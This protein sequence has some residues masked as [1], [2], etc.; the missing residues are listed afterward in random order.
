M[1]L[2]FITSAVGPWKNSYVMSIREYFLI[3][4]YLSA[5]I[6]TLQTSGE[7]GAKQWLCNIK[8]NDGLNL[9]ILTDESRLISCDNDPAQNVLEIAQ[10]IR[11]GKFK[12]SILKTHGYMVISNHSSNPNKKY[13]L[14]TNTGI[15]SWYQDYKNPVVLAV[16]V[17]SGL[18]VLILVLILRFFTVP[19][20]R[21]RKKIRTISTGNLNADQQ[22]E[23]YKSGGIKAFQDLNED[24]NAMQAS[25]SKLIG[26]KDEVIELISHEIKSPLARQRAALSLIKKDS[27][28]QDSEYMERIKLENQKISEVIMGSLEYIKLHQENAITR[29][30]IFDITKTIADVIDDVQ[31]QYPNHSFNFFP[32]QSTQI[33]GDEFLINRALENILINA[34]KYS[35]SGT[36][37]NVSI[38]ASKRNVVITVKDSGPGV[39]QTNIN[40]IFKPY[41]RENKQASQSH[42]LGLAMANKIIELHHGHIE[43]KNNPEGGLSIYISIPV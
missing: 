34:A 25:I 19:I 10:S 18:T 12:F 41:F 38:A 14:L 1:M 29:F 32:K 3:H 26:L 2:T 6:S 31:Y 35:P 22:K 9:H 39:Q 27:N 40:N 24:L 42:G 4:H 20:H 8:K 15:V 13:W 37:V 28:Y 33:D 23:I 21:I 17:S 16:L 11:N 7:S 30:N 43:A 5:A 36:P